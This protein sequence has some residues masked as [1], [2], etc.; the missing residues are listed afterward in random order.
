MKNQRRSPRSSFV[1]TGEVTD[2]SSR[3]IVV[4]LR[5]LNLY[6][7]YVEMANPLPQG[8]S[9]TIKVSAGKASFQA[10]GRIVYSDANMGSGIEFQGVEPRY[11]AILEEWLLEA[12]GI[13][14]I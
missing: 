11:Q 6:G 13:D 8:A 7:C 12:R 14:Q 9:I 5:D 4:R 1:V 3:T 10:R 2:E